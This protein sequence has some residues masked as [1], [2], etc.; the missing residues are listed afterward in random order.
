[1]ETNNYNTA[2]KLVQEFNKMPID[3]KNSE[4]KVYPTFF[5]TTELLLRVANKLSDDNSLNKTIR[6]LVAEKS[7]LTELGFSKMCT[8]FNKQTEEAVIVLGL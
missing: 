8:F 1:M 6:D 3:Y 4:G 7:C 5:T 2:V